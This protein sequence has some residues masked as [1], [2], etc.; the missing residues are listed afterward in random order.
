MKLLSNGLKRLP[1]YQSLSQA[2]KK[3]ALPGAVT[4]VSG[5]HKCG[6][7][8]TLLEETGKRA[9]VL[10]ADE[11]EAQRF[12]EDLQALGNSPVL[13]PLRDFNYRDTAGTSHEYERLRLEALTRI[14]NGAC[15]CVVACMD[16]ALQYTTPPEELQKRLFLLKSGEEMEIDDLLA[17]LVN[18]GYTREEQIEGPGQFSRRGGIVDFFSPGSLN[19]VR[20]EFWGDEIDSVSYFDTATQRRTDPIDEVTLAPCV[21]VIVNEPAQLAGKIEKLAGTL[22]GKTAPKAREILNN[23]AEKLRNG[24]HL[25]SSDKFISMV[26]PRTA[27][28]FDYFSPE[29]SLVVF[30]EGNKLK[31][32]MRTTLWQWGEDLKS[33]LTEGILC[34]GLDRY[35]EDWEYALAKSQALPTLFLDIFARGSYEV[36]TKTL[37]NMTVRQLPV[38]GGGT[39][40]LLDDLSSLLSQG[41]ACVVLAGTAKAASA[42]AEDLKQ[43]GLPASYLEAPSTAAKGTVTVTEGTLSAGFDLPGAG[44]ALITHGRLMAAKAKKAKRDKNSKE[45]S[46]LSELSPGDYVVH[47]AHGIGVFEGIHKLEMNGIIKDYIKVRYA[48]NDTLYVPVTQLDMVSKYIGPREDANVKLSRLGGTDWQRQKTRVRAAVKDIAKDL[49][50]LYA[51][52]MQQ[53]GFA[54]PPDGEWQHDFES[55]FEFEETEDQLR[56]VNEIK[57][58]MERNVPMDRLLCGDVGFGKTEV[59]LR[60]AFKCVAAGK[61]CAILVPTTILAWQHYQTILRRMEGFPVDVELLSRFRT[62]KQQEEILKKVKRGSMDIVVG[63]HR[64]VSKDVQFHDLGL[65]IID[66]EQRFGVA[67]KERLKALCKTADVLTLS[68]TPIPRTLNMALSGIRDM[69]VIEEAPLDRHPVQTYVLEYDT[70]VLYD[71]IRRELRRGGQ[72]YYLH[73]D[74]ASIERVAARIQQSIPEARVGVGHG[75]MNEEELSEIWR[76]LLDHE[77]DILVCTTI[78]ETGVDVPTANTLIIENADRMG[79]SQL[80][81]LRGRVGRSNRRAYAYLTYAPNKVLTEIAQKRLSAIREFTEFGSGFKIAMR[82][83]EIRGAGN[84]LGGEQ[85]GH[86]ETV[87]YDMYIK[88]LGEAVSLMKGEEDVRPVDE[89]CL[90]DMQVEAHIPESYISSTNLRLDVY[91]RIADIRNAEDALDVTDELIDRFGDPPASVKGLLDVALLRNT[92]SQ[93]GLSEIKQQGDS[94]FLYKK[95][96]DLELVGSLIRAMNGRVMLSAGS[97]PYISV[98]IGSKSPLEALSEILSAMEQTAQ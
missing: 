89:G 32:R 27:T 13:Y 55:H 74:V 58:D 23:E 96:F 10:A 22:R 49:I 33:Y 45:I 82:D 50:Q 91:R 47:S 94:L 63:T 1:E 53:Q 61:Q 39:Q 75:K 38:W 15:D 31:E 60:A 16:A 65:V 57:D 85:H 28:L 41:R 68:A 11:A 48:K 54:F 95:E 76:Q 62:A 36:P 64:L 34:K 12:C 35:S 18:C 66:E 2:V 67:Q 51:Q 17:A 29:D 20:V 46:N 25:G 43:A 44:F 97:R 98:K 93:L 8:S 30:S 81:Q 52:R 5:I 84:I 80:H 73:N 6:I 14:L 88:L 79:L 21:E 71:A 86:M 9:L 37:I 56:C 26:Y 83:L 42:L 69:S 24:L 77:I 87:G 59:A 3:N 70:G 90:V 78:I 72:V 92:A 19:P 40:L 4:G 7:V